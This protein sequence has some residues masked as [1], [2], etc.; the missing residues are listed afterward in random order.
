M[1]TNEEVNRLVQKLPPEPAS[2]DKW[3]YSDVIENA[4]IIFD[5][6]QG[7]AVCTRCGK[8]FSIKNLTYIK[9]NEKTHCPKCG[10]DAEYKAAYYGR[11]KLT[12]YF[13]I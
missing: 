6:K 5:N 10:A 9:H 1:A 4:Y 13:R 12:E 7:K 2:V 3:I 11:K 8:E